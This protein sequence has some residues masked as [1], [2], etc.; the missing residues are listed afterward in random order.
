MVS[1]PFKG[2]VGRGMGEVELTDNL[3]CRIGGWHDPR[4]T[5]P[6]EELLRDCRRPVPDFKSF[7][8]PRRPGSAPG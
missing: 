1:S 6:G 5:P 2:E 7:R 8:T 3:V 4:S